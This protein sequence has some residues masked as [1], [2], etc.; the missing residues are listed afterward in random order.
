MA[1]TRETPWE[2]TD[3][4]LRTLA[5]DVGAEARA[6][7]RDIQKSLREQIAEAIADREVSSSARNAR[8]SRPSPSTG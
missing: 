6:Q 2:P 5:A 1:R 8:T 7:S 3:D 4:Q